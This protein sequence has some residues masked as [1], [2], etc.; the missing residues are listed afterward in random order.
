[1]KSQFID[2]DRP[3]RSFESAGMKRHAMSR[4]VDPRNKKRS[5]SPSRL[6]SVWRAPGARARW[7]I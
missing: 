3:G 6:P 5:P 4:E 2:A 7:S 1:L